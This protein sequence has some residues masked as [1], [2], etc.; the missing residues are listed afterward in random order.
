MRTT[1]EID[2]DVMIAAKDVSRHK[3][4]S[5]GKAMSEIARKGLETGAVATLSG[6]SSEDEL[7]RKLHAL[8]VEPFDGGQLVTNEM[9]NALRDEESV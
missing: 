7:H 2:D 9:V 4:I 5:I 1:L 6:F 8:G 3:K